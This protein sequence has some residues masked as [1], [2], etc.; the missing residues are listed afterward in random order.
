MT[1]VPDHLFVYGS[2]RATMP[3]EGAAALDIL[4]THARRAGPASMQGRLYAVSWY[5]GLV[6]GRSRIERVTGDLWRI[7]DRSAL[8]AALDDYE[9]REYVRV[10]R[11]ARTPTGA[12]VRA[13]AY[14]YA[15]D[16]QGAPRIGS[17]DFVEWM[18]TN[19]SL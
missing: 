11:I 10:R 16:L 8:F 12:K 19:G 18:K 7:R 14:I 17:G 6:S 2:L 4:R 1:A 9:G 13:W 15:A 3:G 5:P